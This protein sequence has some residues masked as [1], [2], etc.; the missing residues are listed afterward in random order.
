MIYTVN[1]FFIV[2]LKLPLHDEWYMDYNICWNIMGNSFLKISLKNDYVSDSYA[3][4][5]IRCFTRSYNSQ[6]Q[7]L[8]KLTLCS[9]FLTIM[10]HTAMTQSLNEIY[11]WS[12]KFVFNNEETF[13]LYISWLQQQDINRYSKLNLAADSGMR[14]HHIFLPIQRNTTSL[15]ILKWILR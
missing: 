9:T 6:Y 14:T 7:Y 11:S 15:N 12:H 2:K 8:L 4:N 3:F 5:L 1:T 13:Y 10:K